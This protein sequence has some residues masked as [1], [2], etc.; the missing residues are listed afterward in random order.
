MLIYVP[1]T[2]T[3]I[4]WQWEKALPVEEMFPY[5]GNFYTCPIFKCL[6]TARCPSVD[7]SWVFK[8]VY[9]ARPCNSI[10]LYI[11]QDNMLS[12]P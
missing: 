5:R 1:V 7:A 4:N 8:L 11:C 6:L 3:L 2:K 12:F 9:E 10:C